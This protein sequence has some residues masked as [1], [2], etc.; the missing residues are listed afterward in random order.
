MIFFTADNHFGHQNI[1]KYCKR[2]F[3]NVE[4]MDQT[5]MKN[6]NEVVKDCDT[7]Y[8][9]GDFSF[10][11]AVKT[12]EIIDQ[13]K[14]EKILIKGNHDRNYVVKLFEKSYTH[15]F[16]SG[17]LLEHD[18]EFKKLFHGDVRCICGH[19]HDL[20]LYRDGCLNVGVDCW[21]FKPVSFERVLELFEKA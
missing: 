2:P 3:A 1:I 17:M 7:V 20:F 6:W 9:V 5:M 19:V 11:D 8:I 16:V 13:L 14:G 18:S 15:L 10:Y 4:E 21:S 12:K